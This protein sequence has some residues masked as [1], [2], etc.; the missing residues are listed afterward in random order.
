MM[1][2]D[3]RVFLQMELESGPHPVAVFPM[4]YAVDCAKRGQ[5]TP[6]GYYNIERVFRWVSAPRG[7]RA[8]LRDLHRRPRPR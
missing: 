1:G 8:S 3:A 2:C 5:K 7:C 6:D 4:I